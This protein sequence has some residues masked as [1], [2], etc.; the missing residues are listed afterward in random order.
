MNNYTATIAMINKGFELAALA[1]SFVSPGASPR[2]ADVPE[3]GTPLRAFLETLGVAYSNKATYTDA[4]G[5]V[6]SPDSLVKPG[7]TV[8]TFA[9]QSNG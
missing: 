9:T 4:K 5:N 2:S 7:D 6:L 3:N 1:A 8:M